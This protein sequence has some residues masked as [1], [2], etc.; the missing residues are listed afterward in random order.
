MTR[1]VAEEGEYSRLKSACVLGC[2]RA[3]Q[4]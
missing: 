3:S 1:Y 4:V 2:V